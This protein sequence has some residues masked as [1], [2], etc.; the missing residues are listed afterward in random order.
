MVHK[1]KHASDA[2]RGE[3][4]KNGSVAIA[5]DAFTVAGRRSATVVWRVAC[6]RCGDFFKFEIQNCHRKLNHLTVTT[7][8]E[9]RGDD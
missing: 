6:D 4:F 2:I 9:G 1:S 5:V 7:R 3:S 8:G